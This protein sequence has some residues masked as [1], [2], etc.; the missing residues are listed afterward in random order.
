MYAYGMRVT[1]LLERVLFKGCVRVGFRDRKGSV[2]LFI[3]FFKLSLSSP[4][5]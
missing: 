2:V 4:R 3:L 1:R 5:G